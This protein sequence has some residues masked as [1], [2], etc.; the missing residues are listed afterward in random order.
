MFLRDYNNDGKPDIFT[1]NSPYINNGNGIKVYKNVS[2]TI[3]KF[4]LVTTHLTA[5]NGSNQ[6]TVFVSAFD[7]ASIDDI[8]GDGDL[9]ILA[10]SQI[11]LS[12]QLFENVSPNHDS[13]SYIYGTYCW[14]H[15]FQANS[16]LVTLNWDC[17]KGPVQAPSSGARHGGS[18]ITTLDLNGDGL[19]DV[20]IGDPD[21]QNMI[22]L[23]NNGTT[24]TAKMYATQYQFPNNS[25]SVNVTSFPAAFHLDINDD[26]RR[27]LI[28]APNQ[29]Q[30]SDDT[31]SIWYYQNY[32]AD[33]IPNFVLERKN[34]LS[35]DQIDVGTGAIP[36]F[37]DISGDGIEDLL[38]GNTGYFQNY[39]P[40]FFV[41]TYQSRISYYKN[42]GTDTLPKFQFITDDLA[43]LSAFDLT[44]IAPSFGDL[45]NDG[46]N[47]LIFTETG[48]QMYYFENTAAIGSEATFTQSFPSFTNQNY[49]PNSSPFL[50]DMDEDN[51]LDLLVGQNSGHI[52]LY[53]N[54][55]TVTQPDYTTTIT[56]TLGGI[57]HYEA[58]YDNK[59]MPCIAP[60]NGDTN[61]LMVGGYDGWLHFYEGLDENY[62]GIYTHVD[63]IR[64]SGGPIAPASVNINISDSM[65][66]FVGE[67]TGG[68]LSFEMGLGFVP[69]DTT[70]IFETNK[71]Q[72]NLLIYPN[73]NNGTFTFQVSNKLGTGIVS[74]YDLSGKSVYQSTISVNQTNQEFQVLPLNLNAG[75]YLINVQME[76]EIF[77]QKLIIQ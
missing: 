62:L 27:D 73:P 45:D 72:S 51:K 63:R 15:F 65:E 58:G 1:S 61:V 33:S 74:I 42:V 39:D 4:E 53:M 43:N 52:K 17:H 3:P 16:G 55:G 14:G 49:G 57:Y 21:R 48:G 64:V 47:D 38:I 30:G 67:Q 18:S 59:M 9:D 12:Y 35:Y 46:D 54:Q 6:G 50:Y 5:M 10:Q 29:Y 37:A 28:V 19:K 68:V 56:D 25:D 40:D 69:D 66:V 20:L 76:D 11:S 44:R 24:D 13:L 34:F 31:G 41:V 8:D 70:S 75:I 7:I 26:N 23:L 22:R 2:D 36:T 77:R 32:G 71:P 60:L